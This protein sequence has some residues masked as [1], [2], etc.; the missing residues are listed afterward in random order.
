MTQQ[1]VSKDGLPKMIVLH[2][3]EFIAEDI[4]PPGSREVILGHRGFNFQW[5][6]SCPVITSSP[7]KILVYIEK[8]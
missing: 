3:G 2:V 6:P 5:L 1:A 8:E 4:S 7:L